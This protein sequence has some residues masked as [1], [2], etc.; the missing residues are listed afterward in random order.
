MTTNNYFEE[1]GSRLLIARVTEHE[2]AVDAQT[3]DFALDERGN[4]IPTGRY[5]VQFLERTG[6]RAKV[7]AVA[8]M[9][10]NSMFVGGLAEIGTLCIVGFRQSNQP[11]IL[12]FLP[13]GFN[14]IKTIRGEIPTLHPG[15]FLIQGSATSNS[16]ELGQAFFRAASV[17]FDQFQ[18]IIISGRDYECIYGPLFFTFINIIS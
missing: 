1:F 6:T 9:A 10:G 13:F 14:N 17:F 12:G 16:E 5:S 11:V 3:Q 15:E 2:F 4:Q 18:R 8:S 7:A